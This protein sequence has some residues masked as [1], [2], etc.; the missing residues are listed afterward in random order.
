MSATNVKAVMLFQEA[1]TELDE[2]E[3][4]MLLD[5]LT[6]VVR[7]QQQV[8]LDETPDESGVEFGIDAGELW[9]NQNDRGNIN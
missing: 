4:Q 2:F 7:A 5:M 9:I 1:C 8:N 6:V 3:M